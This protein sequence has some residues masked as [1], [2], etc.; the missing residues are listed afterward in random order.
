MGAFSIRDQVTGWLVNAIAAEAG[1]GGED[2]GYEVTC[3][4]QVTP[5]GN[6]P[7]W[8]LLMTLRHPLLGQPALGASVTVNANVPDERGVREFAA[9]SVK[10]LRKS[11]E[12]AKKQ[13]FAKGNGHGEVPAGLR[14]PLL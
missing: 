13:V 8:G 10:L 11:F 9:S 12:D 5:K 2:F 7:V 3:Q 14:S 6:A 4:F 1:I